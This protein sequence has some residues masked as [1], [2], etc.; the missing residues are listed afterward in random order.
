ML[1]DLCNRINVNIGGIY[2]TLHDSVTRANSY[3]RPAEL[4]I[5]TSHLQLTWYK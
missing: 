4:D 5:V 1:L 3:Q 2:V